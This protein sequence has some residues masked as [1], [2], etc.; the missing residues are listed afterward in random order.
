LPH[1]IRV[2]ILQYVFYVRKKMKVEMKTKTKASLSIIII[3]LFGCADV[4]GGFLDWFRGNNSDDESTS[5]MALSK[6]PEDVD[7][8]CTK[9]SLQ[10]RR[11]GFNNA[12]GDAL[13]KVTKM[14]DGMYPNGRY[15]SIDEYGTAAKLALAEAVGSVSG[16]LGGIAQIGGGITAFV[17]SVPSMLWTFFADAAG[18]EPVAYSLPRAQLNFFG[19]AIQNG[20]RSVG[21]GVKRLG[22]LIVNTG[23]FVI[24]GVKH[25][26][27]TVW[28]F[29]CELANKTK[30]NSGENYLVRA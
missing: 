28:E 26:G 1:R 22:N 23:I 10:N 17:L 13:R 3:L 30:G 21:D 29:F 18:N 20:V 24:G 4:S 19:E 5:L 7:F 2:V 15:P 14:A 27:Q 12:I 8:D 25:I 6:K 16:I 11:G 9:V